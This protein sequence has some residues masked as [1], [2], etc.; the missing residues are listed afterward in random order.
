MSFFIAH[1]YFA[2]QNRAYV[3]EAIAADRQHLAAQ[4]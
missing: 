4:L 1:F 2:A 3:A